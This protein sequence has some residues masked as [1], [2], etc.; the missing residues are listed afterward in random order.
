VLERYTE[1]DPFASL[2]N[3]AWGAE[4]H[5]QALPIVQ[6]L[7]LLRLTHG[8][9]VLDVCC[10]TGQ[11]TARVAQLGYRVQGID[12]SERM[13]EYARQ[14]APGVELT[15]A[16]L[17]SFSLDRTF[18][19][20]YSVFESLNH[21]PDVD[22]LTLGFRCVRRHLR[23]G[24]AFLF[25][26]NREEAFMNHWNGTHAIVEEDS[27]CALRSKYDEVTRVATCN[28]TAFERDGA[29][30]RR[31]DFAIRQTCHDEHQ[32]HEQLQGAGSRSAR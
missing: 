4:Y 32:V 5:A 29:W 3:R 11:F 23:E 18:D 17:R 26:L 9:E 10:G 20:A 12:G 6:R 1:F 16:D 13:I 31:N 27:V 2:Y 21:V 28:I 19:A 25:D 15:V 8:A 7:L 22:G 24:A 30:W 14:N